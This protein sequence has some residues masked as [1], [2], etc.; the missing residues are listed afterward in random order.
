MLIRGFVWTVCIWI[1]R[2]IPAS[3]P[4][5]NVNLN[6]GHNIIGGAK[7][8]SIQ[9]VEGV[10]AEGGKFFGCV[11]NDSDGEHLLQLLDQEGIDIRNVTRVTDSHTGLAF[12]MVNTNGDNA[13]V[14]APGANHHID[15]F[16]LGHS[17]RMEPP[18]A[19]V[20]VLQ[21]EIPRDVIRTAI[22]NC[23]LYTSDAA[24]E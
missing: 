19:K 9:V 6:I 16:E 13:I 10:C 21:C 11:G 23:L 22:Q 17:L 2:I 20:L 14:V 8:F 5:L 4:K 15:A 12:V 1:K 18:G 7:L 3:S 24:D